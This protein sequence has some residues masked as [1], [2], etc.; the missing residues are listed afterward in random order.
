VAVSY[1][2]STISI[3]TIHLID[4]EEME[5]RMN[6]GTFRQKSSDIVKGEGPVKAYLTVEDSQ[7]IPSR[8]D[9][10]T[11][12]KLHVENVGSGFVTNSKIGPDQ[13]NVTL[14]PG[15]RITDNCPM[16]NATEKG[17]TL[18]K[19]EAPPETCLIEVPPNV[20]KELTSQLQVGAQ[21]SYEFRSSAKVTINPSK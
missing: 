8:H 12:V 6:L 18:I 9:A 1:N 16:K 2:Y 3:T 19:K 11:T 15:F 21:Y 17:I 4:P 13:V 20:D 14:Q 7:P 10:K 5:A